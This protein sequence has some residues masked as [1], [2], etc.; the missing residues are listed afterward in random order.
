MNEALFQAILQF[1]LVFMVVMLIP[2]AYR[3]VRGPRIA[4]RLLALDL[5]TTILL[6]IIVLLSVIEVQTLLVD[7]ALA[8]GALAFVSTLA[9]ARFVAE[10]RVF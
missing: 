5:V 2:T 1:T 9:I 3:L 6:A 4:D 10:G 8:L 7:V